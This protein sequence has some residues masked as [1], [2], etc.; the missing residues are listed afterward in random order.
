[1]TPEVIETVLDSFRTWL[2][3]LANPP[4]GLATVGRRPAA[5]TVD[6]QT[7]LSQFV[8]LRHEVNLQTRASRSQQEQNAD[9][10]RQL[11]QALETL[12]Q[13]QEVIHQPDTGPDEEAFRPLFKT[14][15][16]AYDALAL[17]RR[18]VLRVE[19]SLLPALAEFQ[20]LAREAA[21]PVPQ[22]PAPPA[23]TALSAAPPRPPSFWSRLFGARHELAPAPAPSAPLP[24]PVPDSREKLFTRIEP[25]TRRIEQLVTSMVMGYTM[26]VQRIERALQQFDLEPIPTV[27]Q[28]FDPDLMEAIEVVVEPGRTTT[29]V[30][31][32]VRRGYLRYGRVFRFAQVRVAKPDPRA[33][34]PP[35]TGSNG[36]Q[37][38]T[39]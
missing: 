14:L 1:L 18:E 2:H 17:A 32:E 13:I 35:A 27:G 34:A 15:V 9:S 6:L 3:E 26:S 30:I 23:E 38:A 21:A 5:E 8:A 37:A 16:D 19:D 28:P 33:K 39:A 12:H 4:A 25:V 24:E 36:D 11:S 7:L 31:E 29:E 10:L 20:D 22:P